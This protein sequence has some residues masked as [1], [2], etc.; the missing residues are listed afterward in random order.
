[1]VSVVAILICIPLVIR[2]VVRRR[3]VSGRG[4]PTL[5]GLRLLLGLG[6]SLQN[7][8]MIVILVRL[9]HLLAKWLIWLLRWGGDLLLCR[10]RDVPIVLVVGL[11]LRGYPLIVWQMLARLL[12]RRVL[13]NRR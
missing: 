3:I 10:L 6:R 13:A 9:L 11:R 12:S 2:G 1:M 8:R 7:R 5:L 4:I